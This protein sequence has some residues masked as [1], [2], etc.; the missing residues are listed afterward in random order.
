MGTIKDFIVDWDKFDASSD[1]NT[2]ISG[3]TKEHIEVEVEL[4]E[5][6]L[7]L[8]DPMN[9]KDIQKELN[10]WDISIPKKHQLNIDVLSATYAKLIGYKHRITQLMTQAKAWDNT[11]ESAIDYLTDFS[12]GAFSGTAADKKSNAAHI[13]KPFVHLRNQTSILLNYLDKNH[14]SILFCAQQLDLLLKERQSQAKLNH[15]LGHLGEENLSK[16][17]SENEI[18]KDENGD[19]YQTVSKSTKR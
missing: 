15:K 6:Q 10:T 16:I 5:N 13:T 19:I 7:G 14:S 3:V 17:E 2:R 9:Y 12:Q 8:L 1:I 18:E 4:W 11:C